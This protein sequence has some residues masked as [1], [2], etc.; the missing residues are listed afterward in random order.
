MGL[1]FRATRAALFPRPHRRGPVEALVTSLVASASLTDFRA[2]TGAAPL[3]RTRQEVG[4]NGNRPHFRALTGAAPLKLVQPDGC[5]AGL[6]YFRALTGA[7][8]LKHVSLRVCRAILH[9]S[10]PSQARPR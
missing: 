7:A 1:L 5:Y 9:I 4:K 10:A 6:P 8:P 3:K 2:L